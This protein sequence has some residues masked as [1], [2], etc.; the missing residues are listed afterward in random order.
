MAQSRTPD[1]SPS[2][3]AA[4]SAGAPGE[5]A[6]E[7]IGWEAAAA[8]AR[9]LAPAG[10]RLSRREA[11][12][13][14]ES[15]R[16]Q[17]HASVDHVHAITGLAAARNLHDSEVLVVD[18]AGWS[19]ANAQTFALMLNRL[20]AVGPGKRAQDM[21]GLDR[22]VT[23][24]GAAVELGGLLA[25]LSGKVLGQYDPF[26]ALGGHGAPGGRLL[27]VAPNIAMLER[28]LNVEPED[29]R[30]WVC[31]HEQT[32]RVQ[33]AAAPWLRGHLMEL[34]T[35][36]PE[37]L[38][39]G[40]G[41]LVQ[42]LGE[43]ARRSLSVRRDRDGQVASDGERPVPGNRMS[44]LLDEDSAAALSQLT[45]IMSLME[46][47]A[48]VV[49]DAVDASIVPTV[50][51]IR[52]RFDARPQRGLLDRAMR[53]ALGLDLKMRQY[54]D[55]QEFVRAILR[56]RGMDAVNRV[57]EGPDQ[58]PSEREIHNPHRWMARVLDGASEG[59][60]PDDVASGTARAAG[61][62]SDGAGSAGAG[63]DGT[64]SDGKERR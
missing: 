21:S 18:R 61:T 32:H 36:L 53:R 55:G 54:R 50:K 34:I 31:L 37:G 15:V 44:L 48:N 25:F 42:R 47:H 35:R 39:G 51:T 19:R 23:T 8:A 56:E 2:A 38:G 52:R 64:G 49:M 33:F 6:P 12:A 58:L 3:D 29:F 30:L 14:V 20:L 4:G 62:G 16:Y 10:P 9:T 28:E 43:A 27:L 24:A 41:E 17:A 11:G 63:S 59:P 60:A 46:G 22:Q 7:I 40:G 57:W 5:P 45:A 26:A 1:P 13:V